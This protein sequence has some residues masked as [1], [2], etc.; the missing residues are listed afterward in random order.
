MSASPSKVLQGTLT[1]LGVLAA[2]IYAAYRYQPQRYFPFPKP[3][4]DSNPPVDPNTARLFS[5]RARVAVIAAHPDDP[6]FYIGGLLTLLGRCGAK[7]LIVMCT[8]GDKGYYPSF[9]TNVEENRRVRRSEQIEA[10]KTYGAE[11][12]FLGRRDG[13]LEADAE[14]ELEI[15]RIL[16]DFEPEFL[17]GFDP[18]YPPQLQH[19][20]HL[21]AGRLAHRVINSVPSIRWLLR[22]STRASNFLVDITGV[23]RRK[24]ELLAIHRSQ[25]REDRFDFIVNLVGSR[26]K[27]EG[28]LIG[29]AYAEGF[30]CTH[31]PRKPAKAV[32]R[33][34]KRPKPAGV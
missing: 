4:P 28:A 16:T 19:N 7:I 12:V 27:K 14:T 15:V 11:V 30:R 1:A 2:G 23:W 26:A 5:D 29:V 10:A 18:V 8:D 24:R 22:F 31:V 34:A 21:V 20:D 6:E 25:F 13:R 9:L 3:L 17:F 32:T 33:G